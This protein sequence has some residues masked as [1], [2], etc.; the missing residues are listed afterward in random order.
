MRPNDN[1]FLISY[2]SRIQT[3]QVSVDGSAKL[4][5]QTQTIRRGGRSDGVGSAV[6]MPNMQRFP[7]PGPFI[8][9]VIRG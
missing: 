3:L 1:G 9:R 8:I 6:N 4:A 7:L 2:A 5:E